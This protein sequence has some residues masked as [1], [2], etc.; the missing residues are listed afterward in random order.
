MKRLVV[1]ASAFASLVFQ[2]PAGD[3]VRDRL[4]GAT[5]YAPWLLRFELANTAWKKIRRH[6]AD[7]SK[8]IAALAIALDDR[9]GL[10]WRDVDPADTVLLAQATGMTAYDASYLWLAASLGADLV[11]LDD[12]LAKAVDAYTTSG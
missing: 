3:A 10:I 1:D 8:I 2:E 4:E 6:P 9:S 11:T 5:V 12:R 7:A